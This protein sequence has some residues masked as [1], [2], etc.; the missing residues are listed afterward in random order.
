[1]PSGVEHLNAVRVQLRARD[2]I[3]ASMP[4]GVEHPRKGKRQLKP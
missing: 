4:S 2:L 3:A 1:M